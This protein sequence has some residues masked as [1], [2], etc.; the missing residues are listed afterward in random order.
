[1]ELKQVASIKQA[2]QKE[3]PC[4]KLAPVRASG[5]PAAQG[6]LLPVG[7]LRHTSALMEQYQRRM[8]SIT[9]P[10]G[11]PSCNAE[12]SA[13]LEIISNLHDELERRNL[14]L[15]LLL[16]RLKEERVPATSPAQTSPARYT[17]D[18]SL[19]LGAMCF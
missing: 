16:Q 19:I 3:Q 10:V 9:R 12:L 13:L 8:R 11:T 14:E 18:L 7:S 2:K 1:M 17:V 15:G 5:A 4:A 6:D